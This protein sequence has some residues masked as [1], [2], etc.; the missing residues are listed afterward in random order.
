MARA[1]GREEVDGDE[2]RTVEDVMR[3]SRQSGGSYDS[4]LPS[5]VTMFKPREGEN[6]VRIL[7]PMWDKKKWGKGWEIGVY[8]HNRI[9]PDNATYLCLDKMNGETCPVCEA[10]RTAADAEEADAFQPKWRAFCWVIDR[11]N[12][13]AGPMVWNMP[14]TL[15]REIN[16]RSYDKK[17]GKVVLIDGDPKADY[18]G[19]DVLFNR[20]GDGVK[21]KYVSVEIDREQTNIHEDEAR[22]KKWLDYIKTNSLPDIL[23]YFDAEHI[24]RVLFGAAG[25]EEAPRASRRRGAAE[26]DEEETPRHARGRRAEPDEEEAAPRRVRGRADPEEVPARGRRKLS[27]SADEEEAAPRRGRSAPED[28]EEEVPPTRRGRKAPDDDEEEEPAPRR[29]RATAEPDA[30]EEPAPRRGRANGRAAEED[31][32]PP[33]RRGRAG[34]RSGGDEDEEETPTR[35]A[36][37]Q[38]SGL[39]SRAAR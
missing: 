3:R 18:A 39:R 8:L 35:Q 12:E 27:E 28:E 4:Y 36:R 24:E 7:P 26:P 11:N 31:E 6:A 2:E 15:F 1:K 5:E 19:Y 29:G 23:I 21:T 16:A 33:P 32:D 20:E 34:G 17:T 25:E 22:E 30:E 14:V 37:R 9:G 38:L 10:R 13:K